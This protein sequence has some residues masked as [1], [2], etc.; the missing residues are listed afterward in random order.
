MH[1]YEKLLEHFYKSLPQKAKSNERF[2]IPP[3]VVEIHGNRTIIKNFDTICRTLR[4]KPQYLSKFLLKELAVPGE[5]SGGK[6][7]LQG[8]FLSKIIDEKIKK[9]FNNYVVC[10]ECGRPDTRIVE[11]GK[12][13]ILVCEACGARRVVPY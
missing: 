5:I 4:R 7:E 1:D 3:S 10:K 11:E 12:T 13:K 2:E 8:R 6:L 9:Y